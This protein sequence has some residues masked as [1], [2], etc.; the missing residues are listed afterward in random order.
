[1]LA[2]TVLMGAGVSGSGPAAHDSESRLS[3]L[4]PRIARYRDAFY[5]KLIERIPGEHGDRLRKESEKLKQPFGG[6][7]QY[8]NQELARQRA[9]QLQD[10]ELALI[11]ADMGFAAASRGYADRIPTAS[12]RLLS[13][14][15]I[16]QTA[17]ERLAGRG[18]SAAA[19]ALL[20]EVEDLVFRGIDCGAL[21]DPW[22]ILGYQ[23]LYPLFQSRE[24][25]THD[26]RNEELIEALSRQFDLY[27]TLQAAAASA[28]D[29]DL[30]DRLE[31]QGAP[32]AAWWDKF[33]AYEVSDVPRL[34]GGERA[35]AA[36][37]VAPRSPSGAA[38]ARRRA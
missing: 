22:N 37:H 30:L 1:M 18:E 2:G 12:V 29:P 4:V 20:P 26:P 5:T 25:S 16:R 31:T 33:A 9:A 15:A 6:V 14:I 21:A 36:L 24:D 28:D 7:R 10:R 32:L 19:A 8:L 34:H 38:A 13:E 3:K 17:A 35:D 27:S 23:G 11:L